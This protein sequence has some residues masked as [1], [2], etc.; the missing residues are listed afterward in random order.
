MIRPAM[1]DIHLDTSF[2]IRALVPGTEESTRLSN[3]L[4]ERRSIAVSA[5]VWGEFLCGP[6]EESDVGDAGRIAH[7]HIPV[8]TEEA[9][10]A[11][12]LFN[13][14]GRRRGSFSD[15]IVAATTILNGAELATSDVRDF[16]RFIDAGLELAE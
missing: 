16:E 1:R 11:A 8:S 15:C 13:H 4:R 6:L 7:R 9:V 14:G 3:W 5:F 2:L 10:A 12:G